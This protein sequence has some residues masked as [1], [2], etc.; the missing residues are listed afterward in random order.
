MIGS[1]SQVDLVI[2][3]LQNGTL[4]IHKGFQDGKI[5]F[6]LSI[7]GREYDLNKYIGIYIGILLFGIQQPEQVLCDPVGM[8]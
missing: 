1:N 2:W 7:H 4:H 3:Y 5:R 8:L 6:G